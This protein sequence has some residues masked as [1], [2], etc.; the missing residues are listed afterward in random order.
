MGWTGIKTNGRTIEEL[1]DYWLK[2]AKII[3]GPTIRRLDGEAHAWIVAE[4]QEAEPKRL[5][6][7]IV[8]DFHHGMVYF[9]D[10]DETMG[11]FLVDCPEDYLSLCPPFPGSF[12][13]Q[14]RERVRAYWQHFRDTVGQNATPERTM[15]SFILR[16]VRS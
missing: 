15:R 16:E 1:V 9:K 4:T 7:C 11:P 3:A 13:S 14:W 12:S 6:V 10:I 2:D 5:I 8:L